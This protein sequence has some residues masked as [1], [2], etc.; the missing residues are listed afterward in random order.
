M[1]AGPPGTASAPRRRLLL[2]V[3]LTTLIVLG[4]IR[5]VVDGLAGVLWDL[6]LVVVPVLFMWAPV[7]VLRWRGDDPDRYPLALPGFGGQDA[8][9]WREA[10]R[11]CAWAILLVGP[12]YI[13]LYHL[14]H[15]AIF[16]WILGG[17]CDLGGPTCAM[18]RFQTAVGPAW[19]LPAEPLQ[20][21]AY[22]VLFVAIP[23]ELYYRGYVQSRLD[24]VWTPRWRIGGALLGPGWLV[25]CVVFALGHSVV[26]FQWWHL[27]IV[28]PSL[29]FGWM[30][31]RTGG[32]LAGAFF[33]AWCNV[34]VGILDVVYGLQP[35]G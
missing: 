11:L 20:L 14:W 22:H 15:T 5:L 6:P 33:H 8:A 13:A 10:L 17:L 27:A 16:P 28:F 19:R 21:V 3:G 1:S 18:A 4:I 2:E 26:S 31:A 9:E 12:P 23:E 29:V 30:R 24:E 32:V 7:L 34:T 25:T 35:P